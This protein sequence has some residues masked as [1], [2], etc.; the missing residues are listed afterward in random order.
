MR[1][2]RLGIAVMVVALA[3][4]TRGA[5][6]HA[7]PPTPDNAATTTAA[8]APVKARVPTGAALAQAVKLVNDLYADDLRN[9]RTFDQRRTLAEKLLHAAQDETHVEGRYALLAKSRDVA[10]L[11]A[12]FGGASAAIDQMNAAFLIDTLKM[13]ADAAM[14]VSKAMKGIQQRPLATALPALVDAAVMTDRFALAVQLADLSLACARAA[15]ESAMAAAAAD[16]VR[17]VHQIQIAYTGV[18]AAVATLAAQP[19]DSDAN[20]KVGRYRCFIKGDWDN[21]LPLLVLGSDLTLKP[22]VTL[23]LA[24]ASAPEQQMNLGDGW[25]DVAEKEAGM[26]RGHIKQHAARWYALAIANVQGLAKIRAEKRIKEVEAGQV[27]AVQVIDLLKLV[28]VEKDAVVGTWKLHGGTL[29]SGNEKAA[30]IEFPYQPGEEYDFRVEFARNTGA[31]AIF[32]FCAGGGHSFELAMDGWAGTIYGVGLIN[33]TAANSNATTH[34]GL[35]WIAGGQRYIS[36]V[37]VRKGGVQT[38]LNGKLMSEYKTDFSDM[39]PSSDRPLRTP[40]VLGV[41]SWE[42]PTNFYSVE[43]TEVTGHGTRTR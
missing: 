4:V 14:L 8:T 16:K 1:R 35:H 11:N 23:E 30:R 37:K 40:N 3:A 31:E 19:K 39:S 5:D 33:G 21:G 9:A 25:W 20:L 42:S 34:K 15:Q 7:V 38:F 12:D 29:V 26:A 36:V 17:E 10:V 27:A 22:L 32:Q 13:K 28:D 24:G 41:G 6:D 18:K 43:V 2:F